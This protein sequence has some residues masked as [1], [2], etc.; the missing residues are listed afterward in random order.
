MTF[1]FLVISCMFQGPQHPN[2][3]CYTASVPW[4]FTY[5]FSG[6]YA[7]CGTVTKS[8]H[9]CLLQCFSFNLLTKTN[10]FSNNNAKRVVQLMFIAQFAFSES[11]R[12]ASALKR[13]IASCQK[14]CHAQ[15]V[16]QQAIGSRQSSEHVCGASCRV[17]SWSLKF[18]FGNSGSKF[19]PSLPTKALA[20][21]ASEE[22]QRL[23]SEPQLANWKY[24]TSIVLFHGTSLV[25]SLP[26]RLRLK[27][28][29]RALQPSACWNRPV[30]LSESLFAIPFSNCCQHLGQH[31]SMFSQVLWD[32]TKH[33]FPN[34]LLCGN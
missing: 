29:A 12:F 1:L 19:K 22:L 27:G 5:T 28:R 33:P 3:C 16:C 30:C 24:V 15:S 17:P 20:E 18:I 10:G 11:L 21:Q 34:K 9:G 7:V 23:Q 32:S 8:K 14:K 26:R 2:H 25:W 13:M 4:A 6:T 31:R